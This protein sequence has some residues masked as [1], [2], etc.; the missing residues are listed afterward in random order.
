MR[1]TSRGPSGTKSLADQSGIASPNSEY[2]RSVEE[3]APGHSADR[4]VHSWRI[5][6]AGE[7]RDS[8]HLGANI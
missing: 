3:G 1:P 5:A 6:A 7:K 8:F 2:F 4:G